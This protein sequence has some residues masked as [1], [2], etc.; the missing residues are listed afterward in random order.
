MGLLASQ[1]LDFAFQFCELVGP[2]W[3][4]DF[5]PGL[6][7]WLCGVGVVWSSIDVSECCCRHFGNGLVCWWFRLKWFVLWLLVLLDDFCSPRDS[8][9]G[10]CWALQMRGD[11]FSQYEDALIWRFRN[12]RRFFNL[13]IYLIYRYKV[14]G[15]V[16]LEIQA[17]LLIV[18][19]AL[20]VGDIWRWHHRQLPRCSPGGIICGFL[21]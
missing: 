9:V 8:G 7:E 12:E 3:S 4:V 5:A 2:A 21:K 13:Y 20:N 10:G 15:D 17:W 19:V 16:R 6:L 18:F 14:W 11:V 1:V